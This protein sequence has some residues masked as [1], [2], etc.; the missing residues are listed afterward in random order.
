MAEISFLYKKSPNSF[1]SIVVDACMTENHQLDS[2]VTDH[3]VERGADVTD[4]VRPKPAVVTLD[5]VI[6]NTPVDVTQRARVLQ[7]SGVTFES[8]AV[9]Q[10][11]GVAGYA[12]QAYKTL[13]A[14]REAGDYL[15]VVTQ[16]ATYENM[17]IQSLSIPVS[18]ATGDAMRFSV[19]FKEVR[20]VENKTTQVTV[21]APRA[22]KKKKLGPQTPT[23]T[24]PEKEASALK[25]GL[26]AVGVKIPKVVP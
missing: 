9:D 11:T 19:T 5:C 10:S 13:L 15:T 21:S 25:S 4:H 26:D 18:I 14:L 1:G 8:T 17:V 22:K 2:E 16:L 12:E 23:T 6:S 24:T 7:A 20:V 3:P